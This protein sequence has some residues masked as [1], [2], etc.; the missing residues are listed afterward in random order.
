MGPNPATETPVVTPKGLERLD[1]DPAEVE[2]SG[3][4]TG[5]V[6]K[7]RGSL[8][9]SVVFDGAWERQGRARGGRER[10]TERSKRGRDSLVLPSPLGGGAPLLS[11]LSKEDK[12]GSKGTDLGLQ[13]PPR[14]AL[15]HGRGSSG[16]TGAVWCPSPPPGHV[17][18]CSPRSSTASGSSAP[19]EIP[20]SHLPPRCCTDSL[21]LLPVTLR[22]LT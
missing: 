18:S 13:M 5:V 20:L 19:G 15:R 1:Y 6:V 7:G 14:R 17:G 2:A 12:A 4:G 8:R 10:K 16:C 21:C 9:T 11:L 22:G 3:Y